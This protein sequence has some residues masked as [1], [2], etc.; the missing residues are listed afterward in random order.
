VK[1]I[2]PSS[3]IGER[4]IGDKKREKILND[5]K[6]K[7][8]R[9]KDI[10][11]KHGVSESVVSRLKK[12]YSKENSN[13]II[14]KII[15][16]NPEYPVSELTDKS[17]DARERANYNYNLLQIFKKVNSKNIAFGKDTLYFE[18]MSCLTYYKFHNSETKIIPYK[19]IE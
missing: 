16:V 4:G 9:Q 6:D 1:S 14:S 8:F 2:Q 15:A 5:L 3:E 10:A 12:K 11:Q 17:S 18:Q 13:G 7:T 19:K